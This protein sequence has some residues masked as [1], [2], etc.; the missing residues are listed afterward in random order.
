MMR[1]STLALMLAV[2][3][4]VCPSRVSAAPASGQQIVF[5]LYG[6]RITEVRETPADDDDIALAREMLRA[7]GDAT[8]PAQV[9]QAL[10]MTAVELCLPLEE[11]EALRTADKAAAMAD[12]AGSLDPMTKARLEREIASSRLKQA[13]A[14][15]TS[16]QEVLS[17]ARRATIAH[18]EYVELAAMRRE[19]FLRVEES[20]KEAKRLSFTYRL[21]ELR[22]RV[23]AAEE[24]AKLAAIRLRK[25]TDAQEELA[26]AREGGNEEKIAEARRKLGGIYL[27][28]DGDVV[29]AAECL[30]ETD[31]PHA[32]T[33]GK[34]ASFAKD[35]SAVGTD[36]LLETATALVELSKPLADAPSQRIAET[37]MAM[38][39]RFL[40]SNPSAV[41]ATKARLLKTRLKT[42][43]KQTPGDLLVARVREEYKDLQCDIEPLDAERIRALYSF[44]GG[45]QMRDWT[46]REGTWGISRGALVCRTR[47]YSDGEAS[48]KLRFRADRPFKLKFRATGKYE[49]AARLIVRDVD[50]EWWKR[51]YMFQFRRHDGLYAYAGGERWRHENARLREGKAYTFEIVT[52]GEGGYTW[53]INGAAVHELRGVKVD[54]DD[55]DGELHIILR[56]ESSDNVATLFDSV[57]MEGV[58]MI[59]TPQQKNRREA[60]RRERESR[61][62]RR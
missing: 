48:C 45:E 47:P 36:E 41:E 16:P 18:L 46:S 57:S 58:P 9:R 29:K 53:W 51:S 25:I 13:L 32:E 55:L 4:A 30:A 44:R 61:D 23:A 24:L 40:A 11:E 27:E 62:R 17:L 59:L 1:L 21:T 33:L 26:L 43:L 15:R 54:P 50:G 39:E 12:G 2:V 19:E 10:A 20:V 3:S 6:D 14:R 7:A 28:Y 38:V 35:A 49:L 37:A 8:H 31:H 56:T 52:D 22:E 42:V 5:E 60:E 34:A